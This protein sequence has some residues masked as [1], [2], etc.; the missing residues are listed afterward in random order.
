M[1]GTVPPSA[2]SRAAAATDRGGSFNSAATPLTKLGPASGARA[3][4]GVTL[5]FTNLG[6]DPCAKS[7]LVVKSTNH[8]MAAFGPI[9]KRVIYVDSDAPL[10]RDYRR[11]DYKNVMRPIWP[12]DE[13]TSPG[14]IY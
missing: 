6:I 13:E 12:L 1:N 2:S 7:V 9:A 8:F 3:V 14:L 11:I 10:S 5:L 4:S